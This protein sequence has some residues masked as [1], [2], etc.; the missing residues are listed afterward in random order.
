MVPSKTEPLSIRLTEST[1]KLVEGEARRTRRSRG[2]I[3]GE[4]AEEAAKMR[5]FPGL[6]FRGPDPRRPWVIGTGVDVW[7]IVS[8]YRDYDGDLE[9]L[10]AAHESLSERAVR[11]ALAYAERFQAE[12]NAEI[13]ANRRSVED[14]LDELP[15]AGVMRVSRGG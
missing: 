3:V 2:A 4:L 13:E 15:T 14:W 10:L 1:Q 8:M 5:L 6:A 9:K 7:E 11:L 12:I